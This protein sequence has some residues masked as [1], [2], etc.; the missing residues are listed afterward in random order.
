MPIPLEA[1]IQNIWHV[2]YLMVT[3]KEKEIKVFW[4]LSTIYFENLKG[5][6]QA[7][8]IVLNEIY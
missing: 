6:L 1:F 2:E 4:Y 3:R 5:V 8:K 7:I